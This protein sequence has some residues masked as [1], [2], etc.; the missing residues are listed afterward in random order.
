[1]IYEPHDYTRY[2]HLIASMKTKSLD[3]YFVQEMWLEGDVFDEVI[4]GYHVFRHNGGKGNHNFRGVATI[5]LPHC[6]TG[7]KLPEQGPR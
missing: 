7:W 3:V 1:M 2:E 5:L 6:Y 4:N